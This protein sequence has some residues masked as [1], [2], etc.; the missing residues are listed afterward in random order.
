MTEDLDLDAY[1]ARIGY[2]GPREPTLV[3][4]R[5]LH[6]A[7]PRAIP[8]ENLDVLLGRGVRIDLGSIQSKLVDG[9]RG[10]YCFEHNGLFAAVLRGIGFEVTEMAARVQWGR[11]E[12]VLGPRT[13]RFSRVETEEGPFHADVGFGGNT[14]TMPIPFAAGAEVDTGAGRFRLVEAGEQQMQLQFLLPAGWAPVYQFELTPQQPVDYELMNWWVS[15]HP[16]SPFLTNLMAAWVGPDRRY[17]LFNNQLSIYP[18]DGGVQK[19][20]LSAAE[21]ESV[22]HD[23]FGLARPLPPEPLSALYQRIHDLPAIAARGEKQ[24]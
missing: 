1:F 4:L 21:L 20:N 22:M 19:L 15:T 12:A 7:H 11:P 18:H 3:V 24:G 8:F 13:H 9:G 23:T 10:G 17:A 5:A 16:A 6:L 2:S 14:Q